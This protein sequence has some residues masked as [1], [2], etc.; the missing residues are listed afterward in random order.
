MPASAEQSARELLDKAQNH[1]DSAPMVRRIDTTE[2]CA[3]V[4]VGKR[5]VEQEPQTNVVTIEIPAEA[6]KLLSTGGPAEA[7]AQKRLP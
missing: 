1:L 2:Q 4:T 5:R 3:V 6:Q 7:S